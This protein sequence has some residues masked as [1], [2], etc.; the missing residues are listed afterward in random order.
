M[1]ALSFGHRIVRPLS[2]AMRHLAMRVCEWHS[3]ACERRT[4]ASLDDAMLKDIGISRADVER[5]I[6]KPFWHR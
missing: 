2:V 1:E 4:L 5:E 6:A 3:I